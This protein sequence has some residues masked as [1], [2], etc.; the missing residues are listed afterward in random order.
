ME[1]VPAEIW[2]IIFNIRTHLSWKTWFSQ[3]VLT[4]LLFNVACCTGNN[5][6]PPTYECN[7]WTRHKH[8]KYGFITVDYNIKKNGWDILYWHK[9]KRTQKL[10]GFCRPSRLSMKK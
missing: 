8:Y 2:Y 6:S 1:L 9:Y 7:R 3:K 4:E 10:Q 5:Q